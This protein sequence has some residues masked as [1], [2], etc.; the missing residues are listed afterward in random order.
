MAATKNL[1]GKTRD[2]NH[3]YEVWVAGDWEWRILKK[4]KGPEA[5][6]KDRYARWLT[7]VKSPMTYGSY[8]LGDT[9]VVDVQNYGVLVAQEQ[10]GVLIDVLSGG[11]YEIEV[12]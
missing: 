7:A 12:W 2:V 11:P 1:A 9:Y 8:D 6:A 3:P 10:D 4:Y 5:E